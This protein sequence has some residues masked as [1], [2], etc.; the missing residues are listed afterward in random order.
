MIETDRLIVR[1]F[2]NTDYL[3]LHEYLSDP[4]VYEFEPGDPINIDE[5]KDLAAQRAKGKTFYA[6]VL[7]QN[8]F[9]LFIE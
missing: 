6:V 7:K 2:E 5:A 9:W 4:S 8:F 3:D 1:P